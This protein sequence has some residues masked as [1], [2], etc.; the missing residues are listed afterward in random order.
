M[1]YATDL[2]GVQAELAVVGLDASSFPDTDD[3][4]LVLQTGAY[5]SVRLAIRRAGIDPDGLTADATL[6]AAQLEDLLTVEAAMRS[7]QFQMT[8]EQAIGLS[9]RIATM[10]TDLRAAM[11]FSGSTKLAASRR[12]GVGS[13]TSNADDFWP[14]SV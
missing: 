2:T 5:R 8:R 13:M 6:N 3:K 14:E 1:A 12:V 9:Q 4:L 7:G 10:R 11:Q